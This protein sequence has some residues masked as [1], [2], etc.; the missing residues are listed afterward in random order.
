MQHILQRRAVKLLGLLIAAEEDHRFSPKE[1]ETGIQY[2]KAVLGLSYSQ[3]SKVV[4]FAENKGWISYKPSQARGAINYSIT[5]K[6]RSFFC[7]KDT[8][9]EFQRDEDGHY[10][11]SEAALNILQS[12]VGMES[13]EKEFNILTILEENPGT[14]STEFAKKLHSYRKMA[15]DVT[16]GDNAINPSLI[17]K[18]ENPTDARA[19]KLSLSPKGVKRL[20]ALRPHRNGQES[21]R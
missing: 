15:S 7:K 4:T 12:H 1:N 2:L 18:L 9:G 8:N 11:I 5:E 3:F 20:A 10:K 21:E 17:S 6:G 14:T 16:G 13:K 19:L